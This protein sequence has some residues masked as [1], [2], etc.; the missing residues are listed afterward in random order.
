MGRGGTDRT[1]PAARD[2]TDYGDSTVVRPVVSPSIRASAD[3]TPV[4]GPTENADHMVTFAGANR[5]TGPASAPPS[6]PGPTDVLGGVPA[7]PEP[8]DE[9]DR[10]EDTAGGSDSLTPDVSPSALPAIVTS[11]GT[12]LGYRYRMEELLAESP[13]SVTWR[14]F[15][16]VLSRLGGGAPARPAGS[17]GTRHPGDRPARRAGGRLPLPAGARRRAQRGP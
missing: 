9:P 7:T 13:R 12:V 10:G 17:R 5:M 8:L 2:S 16:L 14:A 1:R 11:A 4:A 3:P 6:A 15:D